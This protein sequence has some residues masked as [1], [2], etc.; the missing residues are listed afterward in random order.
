MLSPPDL[1]TRARAASLRRR[2]ATRD[3]AVRM[4]NLVR[5]DHLAETATSV[6]LDQCSLEVERIQIHPSQMFFQNQ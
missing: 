3:L 2:D 5:G 4:W 6:D 1:L